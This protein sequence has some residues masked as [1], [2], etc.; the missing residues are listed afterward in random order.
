ME[1]YIFKREGKELKTLK[2]LITHG[3]EVPMVGDIYYIQDEAY[4][5]IRRIFNLDRNLNV[6]HC[7]VEPYN[8]NEPRKLPSKI[9]V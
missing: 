4:T 6:L 1:V 7:E 5:V 2:T 9:M 8:P 3:P